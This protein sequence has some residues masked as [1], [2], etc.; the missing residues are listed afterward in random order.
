VTVRYCF[1]FLLCGESK[2]SIVHPEVNRYVDVENLWNGNRQGKREFPGECIVP[3]LSCL[4][5]STHRLL[6]NQ[7]LVSVFKTRRLSHVNQNP[8]FDV[9]DITGDIDNIS[10]S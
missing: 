6:W 4:P 3:L 1:L 7:A 10:R 9:D 5:Q 2:N 8:Y